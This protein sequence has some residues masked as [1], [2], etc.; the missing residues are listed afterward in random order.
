MELRSLQCFLS[1]EPSFY[2]FKGAKEVRGKE[3]G[4]RLGWSFGRKPCT[5][6]DESSSQAGDLL[7]GLR[8]QPRHH[9][10]IEH[11]QGGHGIA[12]AW[13]AQPG[14]WIATVGDGPLL[15]VELCATGRCSSPVRGR[16]LR[17]WIHWICPE[18]S[19]RLTKVEIRFTYSKMYHF[20]VHCV[21]SGF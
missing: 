14:R 4:S 5:W 10:E 7:V 16:P 19:P 12:M 21:G 11:C 9:Q 1:G 20:K 13:E 18:N 15:P 8:R 6:V 2:F 17:V 3:K